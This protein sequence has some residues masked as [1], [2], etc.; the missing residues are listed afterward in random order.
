MTYQLR[1]PSS[2]TQLAYRHESSNHITKREAAIWKKRAVVALLVSQDIDRQES[3]KRDLDS[4]LD[5]MLFET[6]SSGEESEEL[7]SFV[8]E[9]L[10]KKE[11]STSA[12]LRLYST[13]SA[14]KYIKAA[15]FDKKD[16]PS[17]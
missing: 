3:R 16:L 15:Y 12:A 4:F 9:L 10:D 6:D 5:E 2:R 13:Y 1:K 8:D 14:H 17:F 7:D 11:S